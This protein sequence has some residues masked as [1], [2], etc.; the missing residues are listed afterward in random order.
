MY[1]VGREKEAIQ[2]QRALERGEN[3]VLMGKYG[4]GRTS[5]IRHVARIARDRWRFIFADFSQTPGEVCQVLARELLPEGKFKGKGSSYK[6]IRFRISTMDFTD[7]RN[8]VLVLDNIGKLSRPKMDLMRYFCLGRRYR[9]VAIVENFLPKGDLF[10]LRSWLNP[11][12]SINISYLNLSKARD[13]FRHY[14]GEYRLPW[15]E[16]DIHNL[17]LMTGGYPLGMKE[18]VERNQKPAAKGGAQPSYR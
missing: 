14:A 3:L 10:L 1:F 16:S 2:I 6:S 12:K 5:L 9:F 11:V 17:A 4:M 8:P 7:Q 18:I 15:T 13:F